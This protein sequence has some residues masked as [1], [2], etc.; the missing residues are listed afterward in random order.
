MVQY[1]K[2][3]MLDYAFKLMVLEALEC[4]GKGDHLPLLWLQKQLFEMAT[5]YESKRKN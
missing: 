4:Y 3:P 2:P 1:D 5:Y